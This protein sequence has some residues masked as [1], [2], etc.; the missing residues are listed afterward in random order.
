MLMVNLPSEKKI[1]KFEEVYGDFGYLG[2]KEWR[3][4]IKDQKMS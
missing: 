3:K 1:G 4:V 2:E